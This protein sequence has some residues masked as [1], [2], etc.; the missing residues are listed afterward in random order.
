[1]YSEKK[2]IWNKKHFHIPFFHRNTSSWRKTCQYLSI[3]LSCLWSPS[4]SHPPLSTPVWRVCCKA[5]LPGSILGGGVLDTVQLLM[6]SLFLLLE[7][8]HL[9]Q[10]DRAQLTEVFPGVALRGEPLHHLIHTG[11]PKHILKWSMTV[12]SF[13]KSSQECIVFFISF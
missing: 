3:L 12:L 2:S 1:M 6:H 8:C 9:L 7:A 4:L 5:G 11:H 13:W 10:S